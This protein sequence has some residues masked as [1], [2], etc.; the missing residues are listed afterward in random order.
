MAKIIS[1]TP[2]RKGEVILVWNDKKKKFSNANRVYHVIHCEQDGK[3][4]PIMLTQKELERSIARAVKNPEDVPK[5]CL[6]TD[7]FD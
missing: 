5:K 7:L 4:F 6:I 1:G 3:E 2:I